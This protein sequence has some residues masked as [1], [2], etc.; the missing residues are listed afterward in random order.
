MIAPRKAEAVLWYWQSEGVWVVSLKPVGQY[1]SDLGRYTNKQE[2]AAHL[3]KWAADRGLTL[4]SWSG[5]LD[6]T[7]WEFS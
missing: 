3:D 5:D 1:E 7:V 2:A 4:T 6:V